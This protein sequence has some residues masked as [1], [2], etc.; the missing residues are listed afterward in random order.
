MRVDPVDVGN[1][2][3]GWDDIHRRKAPEDQER[4]EWLAKK[5]GLKTAKPG[6]VRVDGKLVCAECQS[7]TRHK[8]GCKLEKL[9]A[10]QPDRLCSVCQTE[11][12]RSDNTSG[13][14]YRCR[15]APAAGRRKARG[16]V[17]DLATLPEDRLRALMDK[18]AAELRRR[19]GRVTSR[20][21]L[22]EAAWTRQDADHGL[23]ARLQDLDLPPS[24]WELWA[25]EL[26]PRDRPRLEDL[27]DLR[28]R[29]TPAP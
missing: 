19:R 5:C 16:V 22:E 21:C 23:H 1:G 10:A 11:T 3:G 14:C 17:V 6:R 15:A 7:P 4:S 12:I 28:L 8:P 29:P 18:A 27:P 9:E 24:C 2:L 26:G 13:V 20:E 25:G